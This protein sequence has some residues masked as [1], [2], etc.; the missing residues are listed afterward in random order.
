MT[1]AKAKAVVRERSGGRCEVGVLPGC[2][3]RAAHVHHCKRGEPRVHDPELMLDA[4]VPCHE[5]IHRNTAEAY[6]K[7]WLIRRGGR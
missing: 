1:E 6:E 5:H 7:G 4:C 3:V 2:R